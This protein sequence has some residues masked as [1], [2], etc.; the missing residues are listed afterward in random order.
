MGLYVRGTDSVL[1]LSGLIPEEITGTRITKEV[2]S[3]QI[4]LS[5]RYG[6]GR[7]FRISL[8]RFVDEQLFN[9]G[10]G[11]FAGEGT[12]RGKGTPFEFAN[13]NPK[14]IAVM[15]RLLDRLGIQKSTMTPRLQ[16]RIPNGES[17]DKVRPLMEFWSKSMG[18]PLAKFRKP[19]VRFKE[20]AGRSDYGTISIRINSGIVGS[21]FMFW[22]DQ[23]T[24]RNTFSSPDRRKGTGSLAMR[25]QPGVS[26][27]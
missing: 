2:S 19:S 21:L 16:I 24:R 5:G 4:Q 1:D 25:R 23:L 26:R 12:K 10:C 18:I 6:N 13:S 14:I 7:K 20:G 27:S 9:F 11:L 3:K 15:L 17:T 22:T 8:N